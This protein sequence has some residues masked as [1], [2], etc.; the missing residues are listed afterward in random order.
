[1]ISNILIIG[2]SSGI[3]L[4]IVKQLQNKF[5]LKDGKYRLY[6]TGYP[7]ETLNI[8]PECNK[9]VYKRID[10]TKSGYISEFDSWL[11]RGLKLPNLDLVVYCAAIGYVGDFTQQHAQNIQDMIQ[12]NYTAPVKL[13]KLFYPYLKKV[14]SPQHVHYGMVWRLMLKILMVRYRKADGML[15]I[16]IDFIPN[17]ALYG[18]FSTKAALQ[19]FAVNI[20]YECITGLVMIMVLMYL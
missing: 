19:Q 17:T 1:M 20:R 7:D 4:E 11:F 3:G 13:T 9:I 18:I 2:G 14:R 10:L 6:V 12:I 16:A 15:G 5:K 8:Y